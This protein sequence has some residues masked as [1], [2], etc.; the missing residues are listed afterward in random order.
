MQAIREAIAAAR[1]HI[2]LETYI[3]RTDEVGN[4]LADL[5]IDT[6]REGVV[7]NLI[8]DSFGARGT[9][10]EFFERLQRAGIAVLEYN[11]ITAENRCSSKGSMR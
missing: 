6:R 9:P 2:N 5:L 3:I 4:A 10:G 7:V 8:F 1:D 11:P